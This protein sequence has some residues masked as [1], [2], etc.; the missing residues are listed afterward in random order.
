MG[1]SSNGP[2]R[3]RR[4]SLVAIGQDMGV[5]SAS[6]TLPSGFEIP[7][8]PV[9]EEFHL[10]PRSM[11]HSPRSS[12]PSVDTD[13]HDEHSLN[14]GSSR[15]AKSTRGENGSSRRDSLDSAS[16]VSNASFNDGPRIIMTDGTVPSR[17]TLFEPIGEAQDEETVSESFPP[18]TTR[19]RSSAAPSTDVRGDH[20]RFS[21][22]KPA[23]SARFA[24]LPATNGYS[25]TTPNPR[26]SA[27]PLTNAFSFFS[28]LFTPGSDTS[29]PPAPAS[30]GTPMFKKISSWIG[31][32]DSAP[33][34][35]SATARSSADLPRSASAM[36]SASVVS[37]RPRYVCVQE[38]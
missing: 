18:A 30:S 19:I 34:T 6:Q 36:G 29:S 8:V 17:D 13:S 35:P 2:P 20:H 5:L 16:I 32:S 24:S 25:S 33:S 9:S 27:S 11:D 7:I 26:T 10:T 28:K 12:S 37:T 14:H 3:A 38:G 4:K 15:S 21:S 31:N 22:E 23:L 1:D